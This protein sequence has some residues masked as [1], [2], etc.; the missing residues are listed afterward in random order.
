VCGGGGHFEI[1]FLFPRCR[2]G[3]IPLP[4]GVIY[5]QPLFFFFFLFLFQLIDFLSSLDIRIN[6][7]EKKRINL[8]IFNEDDFRGNFLAVADKTR[9]VLFVFIFSDFCF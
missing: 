6:D 4:T 2:W 5:A 8:D 1:T 7:V 9:R 3:G